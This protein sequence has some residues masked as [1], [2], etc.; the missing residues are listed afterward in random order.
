[1]S[2]GLSWPTAPH[3]LV[4]EQ[5]SANRQVGTSLQGRG[6]LFACG[7]PANGTG[8]MCTPPELLEARAV[9][10]PRSIPHPLTQPCR[11]AICIHLHTQLRT[12][13]FGCGPSIRGRRVAWQGE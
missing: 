1:M 11:R 4:Q 5:R 2:V 12:A 10:A 13:A 8:T 6:L 3:L 9:T 7:H